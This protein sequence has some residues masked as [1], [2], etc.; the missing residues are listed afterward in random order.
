[1]VNARDKGRRGEYQVGQQYLEHMGIRLKRDIEQYRSADHGDLLADGD[2]DWPFCIEVKTYGG[3]NVTHQPSWWQQVSKAADAQKLMP[4]LWYKYD[5]RD[6][7]VV[8]RANNVSFALG[9]T[10]GHDDMLFTMS[11][12]ACFYISREILAA[13][14]LA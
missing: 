7:R 2:F 1:M 10:L 3:L 13:R 6:W 4:V 11:A 12:D 5:R 9:G 8:M 14:A